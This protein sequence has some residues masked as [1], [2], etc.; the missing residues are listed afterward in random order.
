LEQLA[1]RPE[2]LDALALARALL[3]PQ[4]RVAWLGVL[5]APWCGLSL[6]DLHCIA[7]NDD[8]ESRPRSLPELIAERLP[9]LSEE[10]QLTAGRVLGTL[11]SAPALRA[12]QPTASLGTWLE[13]IWLR[14][15]GAACVD[16]T[17]RANLDLLW[18]CL[19]KLMNG[20]PEL[21]GPGLDAALDKLTALPDPNA[22]GDCGV[23]LMTIH[24][25]K[26]LE[27]E[28][29]IVPESHQGRQQENAGVAG[30][31]AGARTAGT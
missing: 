24:K 13:Q 6:D 20:E 19:D 21:L 2:V 10:G 14:L 7:G 29:V 31:R 3:N 27:F 8:S 23:Q 17:A 22:S 16:A 26:G 4:D 15:G 25:S 12:A 9:L 18:S 28:V 11:T 30:T 1:A 5:R